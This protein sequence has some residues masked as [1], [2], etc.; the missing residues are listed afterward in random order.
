LLASCVTTRNNAVVELSGSPLFDTTEVSKYRVLIKTG[1]A[2]ITGILIL[3]YID[4]EWRGSLINEFGIKAFDFI[5]PKGKCKLQNT[6]SFLDK[7]Y[8]RKTVE[9]DFAFLFWD[10]AQGKTV[11]GK[12]LQRLSDDGWL[13]KNEKRK[14]EYLFQKIEK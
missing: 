12:S 11:K 9:G 3:K 13:L 8:I 4:D 6:I 10:A 5:A 2:E 1:Q 7:W 14:I